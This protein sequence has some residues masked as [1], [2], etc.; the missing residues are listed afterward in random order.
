MSSNDLETPSFKHVI[1]LIL[2]KHISS[3]S[4]EQLKNVIQL[5]K[6]L[7]K[8]HW[9]YEDEYADIYSHIRHMTFK[10]FINHIFTKCKKLRDI[11]PEPHKIVYNYYQYKKKIPVCGCIILNDKMDK[12][13]LVT[14]FKNKYQTFPRGKINANESPYDCAIREVYEEIGQDV[15][16]YTNENDKI[17]QF[18]GGRNVTMFLSTNVPENLI[19]HPRTKKEISDIKW[20]FIKNI[21]SE[22]YDVYPFIKKL[23]KWIHNKTLI[24]KKQEWSFVQSRKRRQRRMSKTVFIKQLNELWKDAISS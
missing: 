22:T 23:S 5:G 14:D 2:T 11:Y 24:A 9:I 20:C 16:A 1:S 8:A 18:S 10:K 15:S 21:P 6:I 12:V 17:I 19:F 7:E 13:L 3:L 4:N